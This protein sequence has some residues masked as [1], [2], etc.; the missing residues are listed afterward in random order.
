MSVSRIVGVKG[1]DRRGLGLSSAHER[2]AVLLWAGERLFV[3]EHAAVFV[4]AEGLNVDGAGHAGA[5]AGGVAR[6]VGLAIDEHGGCGVFTKEAEGEPVIEGS[7]GVLVGFDGAKTLWG[8][9]G[10]VDGDDVSRVSFE[11]MLLGGEVEHVIRRTDRGAQIL[12]GRAAC[13]GGEGDGTEWVDCGHETGPVAACESWAVYRVNR[14]DP[15]DHT[16]SHGEG[17]GDPG[18]GNELRR[19]DGSRV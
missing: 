8:Y 10:K 15:T 14:V 2:E 7:R 18:G 1:E 17:A 13:D 5:N 4:R 9:V 12:R 19:G 6:G 3:W 11:E 16:L